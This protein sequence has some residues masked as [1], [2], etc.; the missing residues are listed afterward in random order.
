MSDIEKKIAMAA[1]VVNQIEMDVSIRRTKAYDE[2]IR[3][4]RQ[5]AQEMQR[6]YT[7]K[8]ILAKLREPGFP[9]EEMVSP[10]LI[11]VHD[12][13][14]DL[15]NHIEKFPQAWGLGKMLPIEMLVDTKAE[16]EKEDKDVPHVQVGKAGGSRAAGVPAVV[17]QDSAEIRARSTR[18]AP[19]GPDNPPKHN[20]VG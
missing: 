13:M 12:A 3:L 11:A 20:P 19:P 16:H 2:L 6:E 10:G 4:H 7:L 15:A 17:D 14:R 1:V 5:E 8:V 18:T 9:R